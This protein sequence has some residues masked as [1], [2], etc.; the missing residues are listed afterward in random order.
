MFPGIADRMQREL[1]TLAPSS[2]KVCLQSLSEHTRVLIGFMC[3]NRSRSSHPLSAS[4][5]SGSVVPF[6]LRSRRSRTSGARSRSTTSPAP[7]SSTASASKRTQRRRRWEKRTR[8]TRARRSSSRFPPSPLPYA[9]VSFFCFVPEAAAEHTL[10]ALRPACHLWTEFS[11]FLLRRGDG[12]GVR[13]YYVVT[14]DVL[15]DK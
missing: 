10:S 1:T 2:M 6:S 12:G 4:T 8:C 9:T 14:W 11:L 15:N 13:L 5:P 7:A 3:V